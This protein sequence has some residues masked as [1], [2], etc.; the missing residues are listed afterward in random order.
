MCVKD[1]VCGVKFDKKK[2]KKNKQ[3]TQI[4]VVPYPFMYIL[5]L[6]SYELFL[7]INIS[8]V[9]RYFRHFNLCCVVYTM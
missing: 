8:Y 7:S 3:T 2:E 5:H 4:Y 6:N 9:H 1:V